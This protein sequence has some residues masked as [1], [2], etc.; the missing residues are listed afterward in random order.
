MLPDRFTP[1]E[2]I[3]VRLAKYDLIRDDAS[4]IV[5]GYDYNV[6]AQKYYWINT[7]IIYRTKAD[8]TYRLDKRRFTAPCK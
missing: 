7:Q 4:G 2:E 1:I 5:A 8:W 3:G 6:S